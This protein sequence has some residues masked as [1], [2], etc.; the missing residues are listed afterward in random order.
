MTNVS[1]H[2]DVLDPSRYT[3]LFGSR[4]PEA[5][6][7]VRRAWSESHRRYHTLDHHLVPM[8]RRIRD[9]G[10]HWVV[11]E[12]LSAVALFHDFV[13]DVGRNDNERRS[14]LAFLEYARGTGALAHPVV[15]AILGTQHYLD[16][17]KYA[18]YNE[19]SGHLLATFSDFDL[20]TLLRGTLPEIEADGNLLAQEY[21]T[22][23]SA[24]ARR[25]FAQTFFELYGSRMAEST[26][27]VFP[28]YI[29]K[30]DREVLAQARCAAPER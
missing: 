23:G 11:K 15:V 28:Q 6:A 5:L 26:R 25:S 30:L 1:A 3:S 8:L 14:A 24:V 10:A 9:S 2:E 12:Q 22:R 16:R 20:H 18:E 13:Y 19:R 29:A 7:A 21:G 27:A 17:K 4:A